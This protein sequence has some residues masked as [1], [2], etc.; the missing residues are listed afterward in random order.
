MLIET[1][2]RD[3]TLFMAASRLSLQEPATMG[4]DEGTTSSSGDKHTSRLYF[5]QPHN[6]L[7]G[8]ME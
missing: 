4:G 5:P 8:R 6:R 1:S 3:P 7:I 2:F